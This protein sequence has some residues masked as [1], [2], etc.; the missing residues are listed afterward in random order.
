MR[1]PETKSL[2]EKTKIYVRFLALALLIIHNK[3][4]LILRQ[5]YVFTFLSDA[6]L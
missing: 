5:N 1:Q 6:V 4:C 3:A 2:M